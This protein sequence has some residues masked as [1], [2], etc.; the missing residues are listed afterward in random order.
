MR[1]TGVLLALCGCNQIFGLD[2]TVPVDNTTYFDA[3]IDAPFTCPP[4]GMTPQ[5]SRIFHQIP[6]RCSE[7]TASLTADRAVAMCFEPTMQIAQGPVDGPLE[8]I[9]GFETVNKVHYDAPKLTPEGDEVVLRI[10]DEGTVVGRF[11]MY[12]FEGAS[13]VYEYDITLPGGQTIDSFARFSPPS[14]GPRRRML[15]QNGASGGLEEIEFDTTGASIHIAS[16]TTASL[17]VSSVAGIVPSLTG[18]GLHMVFFAAGLTSNGIFYDARE[19]RDVPF[20]PASML[21]NVPPTSDPFM[22]ESCER[23]YFSAL[24]SVLWVQQL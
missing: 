14:H 22:T 11:A 21:M 16:Y 7:Y 5:F 3:P 17:G 2:Q 6:Q 24:G 23:I 8:P 1:F 4:P 19:S 15:V 18:D 9:A 13:L 10:W 20:G 12:R